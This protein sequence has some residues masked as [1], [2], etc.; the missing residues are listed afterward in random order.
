MTHKGLIIDE[1]P[2][3]KEEE[4]LLNYFPFAQKVQKIIQGHSKNS[5]PLTIGIYGKWGSGKT[6]FLNLI[7]KNIEI[8]GKE[9]GDKPY[10]KFHYSPWL[11]QT[12]EEMLFDF[13]DT[14][15]RKLSYSNKD[16]LKKAGKLI[17]KYSRYLKAVKISASVGVPKFLN[18]GITFEPHEI[19]QK[20]GEDLEGEEKSLF[21]LKKEIDKTLNKA[22]RKIIIFIDD[23]DR[24]DKEEIF[25]LF[26]LIKVNADFKN[27]IFIICLDPEHVAKA[28]RKRY[29][30]KKSGKD[31]LEK[32]INI[33]LEL[34]LIEEA[35]LN[36]FVT[37]KLN[38]VLSQIK[39]KDTDRD[40]L[41]DSL[42]GNYFTSPREIIRVLNS[43]I[44][45]LYAIG[46][47]VN[48]H[49][50][51]WIEYLKVKY[52]TL[53][54]EIK[55]YAQ[56]LKSEMIFSDNI[57][58]TDPLS[59][60]Q[61]E[62]D[63]RKELSQKYEQGFPIVGNLFP[64]SQRGVIGGYM[65][66]SLKPNEI[67]D[68]ELRIN[69]RNHFEKYFSYHVK[70]KI[71]EL[72]F[73]SFKVAI[74][75]NKTT[76]ALEILKQIIEEAGEW[77]TTYRLTRE[78]EQFPENF[79]KDDKD[80]FIR[81][82]IKNIDLFD[83]STDVKNHATEII[84]TTGEVLVKDIASNKELIC[85]IAADLNY[86]QLSVFLSFIILD[87]SEFPYKNT[88]ITI[89]IEK[90]KDSPEHPFFIKRANAKMMMGWWAEIDQAGLQDYILKYL[91]SPKNLYAFL[92]CF[93]EIW[94]DGDFIGPF[95]E[96]N[97]QFLTQKLQFRSKDIY[98]KVKE[99]ITDINFDDLQEDQINW[100][101]REPNTG[102]DLVRQFA[103]WYSKESE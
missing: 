60:E 40:E 28:I 70:G 38:K 17:K 63:F 31:F 89:L 99:H 72:K 97:Y 57:T 42:K 7:E 55:N 27:L 16:S 75:K 51:F 19:L 33:P 22:K 80:N 8:F 71:S 81:L 79:S 3:G 58:F 24:L 67:L 4:D 5:E 95:S 20:L 35:D 41:I 13:F 78:I 9:T 46:N 98:K 85:E 56:I 39:A 30:G 15:S 93:P 92:K 14:L 84:Q 88:I 59:G 52:N 86:E 101:D 6:S 94:N 73:S 91:D 34:P 48:L 61:S 65:E 49:D 103:Y 90:I 47:E 21:E 25:T 10:I 32:I 87:Q 26:K 23:I 29:G 69:H 1:K 64:I 44:V 50:L 62:T 45:S 12:K 102:P 76:D 77:K 37:E 74:K 66:S 2:I 68:S 43:F 96:K 100:D 54:Q 36:R 53:Y 83:K 11:Y 82:L 18:A